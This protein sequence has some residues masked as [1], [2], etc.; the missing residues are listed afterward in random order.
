MK[1]ENECVKTFTI[2]FYGGP[3]DGHSQHALPHQLQSLVA[4]PIAKELMEA[5]TEKKQFPPRGS[6]E[7]RTKNV[8]VYKL[9]ISA[10]GRFTYRF[11]GSQKQR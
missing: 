5:I 8:A 1:M 9:N 7:S 4:L 2:S 6:Y 3:Y 11:Q 10:E